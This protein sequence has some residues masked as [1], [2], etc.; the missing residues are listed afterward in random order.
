MDPRLLGLTASLVALAGTRVTDLGPKLLG[1]VAAAAFVATTGAIAICWSPLYGLLALP[2]GA[3]HVLSAY[4]R[5]SLP[6]LVLTGL[7]SVV[8][9]T[10]H[11]VALVR[12]PSHGIWV[13][14][15]ALGIALLWLA[16]LFERHRAK[17]DRVRLRLVS[18]FGARTPPQTGST[19]LSREEQRAV[20]S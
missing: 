13:A 11:L 2:V 15:A 14:P 5:R 9:L 6:E 20:E 18:H 10:V 3:L 16:S 4:E 12:L 19:L 8:A 7:A 17:L 1:R